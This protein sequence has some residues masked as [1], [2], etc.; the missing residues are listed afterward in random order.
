MT[1]ALVP[2]TS[3]YLDKLYKKAPKNVLQLRGSMQYGDEFK[4]VT[5]TFDTKKYPKGI[6]IMHI[7]DVQFGHLACNVPKVIEFFDWILAE[8]NRFVVFGGDMVDAA[9]A[10]SVGS[11]FENV[12]EPQGEVYRFVELAVRIRH[13]I[14]GYVGGNHERRSAKTFGD[15]GHM[16]ASLLKVPY[17]SGKQFVDIKYGDHAPFKISLWHGGTGSKTKGAKIQMLHRFMTQGTAQLYMVGHLHDCMMTYDWRETRDNGKIR[18]ERFAGV[19]SSSF[20]EHYGCYS[21]V[22]GMAAT[23]IAMWRCILEPDGHW[24]LTIK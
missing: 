2:A 11:P 3:D 9:H 23:G 8:P 10:L 17:S 20:L 15:L 1:M 12:C 22:A 18:L 4:Y 7:T 24:M 16:I 5:A 14:I 21:E 6:E 13:R 19:M